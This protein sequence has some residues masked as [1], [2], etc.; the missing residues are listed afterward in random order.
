MFEYIK[1]E[2]KEISPAHLII[3][4]NQIGYFINISV[5]TYSQLSGQDNAL[6]YIYEVI[7]EDAHHLFGFFE[8]KEREIFLHLISVS[9]VGANTARV[10]LSS[11]APTEI[12]NAISTGNVN[13]LKSI[14]GIGAKTAERIIV[15]LKDK[16]GKI[17]DG[18]QIIARIDNTIKDEALSALVM[19]GFPKVKV[20][21]II[22][23]ILK[24]NKVLSVEELIKE[25]LKRI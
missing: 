5:N 24:Q 7:R 19:L 20:D 13:I 22:N 9:G 14:K 3:E 15:D 12:Q 6:V 21:K 11:L 16:V 1:G 17:S 4:N 18:E 2:I 23:E 10:M 25:A 8:K